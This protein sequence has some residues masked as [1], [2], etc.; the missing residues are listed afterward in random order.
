MN[1][2]LTSAMTKRS[3]SEGVR[4]RAIL[5]RVVSAGGAG[6]VAGDWVMVATLIA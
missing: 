2:Q 4:A 1:N 3:D 6:V 5:G